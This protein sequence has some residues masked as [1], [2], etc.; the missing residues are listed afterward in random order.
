VFLAEFGAD[1]DRILQGIVS[2]FQPSSPDSEQF[3]L[4]QESLKELVDTVSRLPQ[5][6]FGS[7]VVLAD[8]KLERRLILLANASDEWVLRRA[9]A[10]FTRL[11]TIVPGSVQ[12]PLNTEMH[13]S[14]IGGFPRYQCAIDVAG[15]GCAEYWFASDFQVHT[16]LKDL[17]DQAQILGHGV[18]Y[19]AN[20]TDSGPDPVILRS[21]K[22]N[23]AQLRN[24]RAVPEALFEAQQ[25]LVHRLEQPHAL[26][27]EYVGVDTQEAAAWLAQFLE[28][29]FV[30]HAGRSFAAPEFAFAESGCVDFVE[31]GIHKSMVGDLAVDEVCSSAID[32]AT[33]NSILGWCPKIRSGWSGEVGIGTGED[34]EIVTGIDSRVSS[35]GDSV[36]YA[37]ISYKHQDFEQV[38]PTLLWMK[39]H[40]YDYWFDRRIPGGSEWDE[41]IERRIEG[42]KVLLLFLTDAAL[43]SKFVRREVKFAD[44]I[45]K[46][47][48]GIYLQ[49]TNLSHGLK[50][51]LLT[52]QT[53][54]N[55]DPEYAD[56]LDRALRFCGIIRNDNLSV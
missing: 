39:D 35:C 22:R 41:E 24:V 14:V 47:I 50:M 5:I 48:V 30:A 46:P 26:I 12:I 16:F 51:L 56:Q 7:R 37:F 42:C 44:A 11:E 36:D 40:G 54:D 33:R 20:M 8:G 29:R 32:T 45:G 15:Y 31:S 4:W 18:G 52:C 6:N 21:A 53:I 38:Q 17:L 55:T 19:Q 28:S 10:T 23:L 25:R 27:D 1:Q 9:L 34:Q 3:R 43:Q 49:P 13:D 2:L